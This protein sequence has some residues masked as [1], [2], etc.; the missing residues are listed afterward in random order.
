[1]SVRVRYAPSPTGQQHIGGIRTALFNYFF[2]RAGGGT[3]ILRVE[4]TDRER[5]TPDA[6][7]DLYATL[8]WLG[9][10]YDEGPGRDGGYGPYVQSERKQIY[11]EKADELVIT[12]KAY[13]CFCTSERLDALRKEQ[14]AA[15]KNIGY[16]RHCREISPDEAA[17]R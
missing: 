2:A 4:D 10:E 1:M 14:K 6:L 17:A 16:D 5:S 12:G 8:T 13:P 7:E 3:F 11:R 9:V 15:R